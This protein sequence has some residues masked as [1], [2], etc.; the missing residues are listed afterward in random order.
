MS[1]DEFLEL[2]RE[3]AHPMMLLLCRYI[4][5]HLTDVRF[6]DGE[7]AIA[8]APREFPS[9]HV[10]SVYPMRRVSFYQLNYL[11]EGL[12]SRKIDKS[13]NVIGINVVNLHVD[14]SDLSVLAEVTGQPD[15]GF[16][17][18]QFFPI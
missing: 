3:Q 13:M 2:L 12:A 10:I 14:S 6:R 4:G 5:S 17:M 8:S 18:Q 16:L 1:I 7:S 15:R 11:F 9:D